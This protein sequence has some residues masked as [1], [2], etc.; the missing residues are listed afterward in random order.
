VVP[1]GAGPFW[2]RDVLVEDPTAPGAVIAGLTE[3]QAAAAVATPGGLLSDALKAAFDPVGSASAAQAAAA[4]DATSKVA[5]LGTLVSPVV[6]NGPNI[7]LGGA[8][9]GTSIAGDVTS[10]TILN[11]G[12]VGTNNVIGGDGSATVGTATPNAPSTGTAANVSVIGGY[13]NVAGALSSKIISDHSYVGVDA[14]VGHNAI[15]GGSNN[16]I[17]GAGIG[18]AGIFSGYQCRV[19]GTYGFATGYLNDVSGPGAVA[20]GDHQT[21]AGVGALATGSTNTAS[22]AYS[23]AHGSNSTASASYTSAEGRYALARRYGQHAYASGRAQNDGDVQTSFHTVFGTTVGATPQTLGVDGGATYASNFQMLRGTTAVV[24]AL[25]VGRTSGGTVHAGF[26]IAALVH[27]EA[28]GLPA[29]IG[30][31]VV[32]NLNAGSGTSAT[33]I[34]ATTVG[35]LAVQVTGLAATT[36]QWSARIDVQ[37]S[38]LA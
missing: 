8:L 28:A 6:G 4:V 18:H 17:D 21:V 32:E 19:H 24:T 15:F 14:T 33:V 1:D 34:T 26:R 7:I 20:A 23:R 29:V 22:G 2:L 36:I 13:D 3:V 25:V 10:G 11:P 16:K 31:P 9:H 27:F 30:T 37:E 38:V 5:G 35:Q 12:G